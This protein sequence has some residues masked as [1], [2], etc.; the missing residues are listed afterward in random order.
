MASEV[1]KK[2]AL[3]KDEDNKEEKKVEV[4]PFTVDR[5]KVSELLNSKIC[6]FLFRHV[7]FFYVC[8]AV[9]D[10][11]TGKENHYIT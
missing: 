10:V 5:E 11:T 7:H 8:S 3:P 2:E 9:K 1:V 4:E 6:T